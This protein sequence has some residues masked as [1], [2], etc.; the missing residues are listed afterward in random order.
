[1]FDELIVLTAELGIEGIFPLLIVPLI[2]PLGLMF[3]FIGFA[4]AFQSRLFL[5]LSIAT[6]LAIPVIF[7]D[8]NVLRGLVLRSDATELVPISVK[9]FGIGYGIGFLASMPF[10]ALQ[11]AGALTDTFRGENDTGLH[12]PTGGTLHTFSTIYLVVGFFTFF[13]VG[14]FET[15][16]DSFYATY[17]V[18]PIGS[19][20]PTMDHMAAMKVMDILT[21]TIYEAFRI[22]LPLLSVLILIEFSLSIAARLGRRFNMYDLA[23]PIKNLTTLLIMPLIIWIVWSLSEDRFASSASPLEILQRLIQ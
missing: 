2:R 16:L 4:W 13:S 23:F 10:F 8:L 3:G 18:W 1:M 7:I 14:G 22:A 19:I 15:M 6:T 11:Y 9:E 17:R 12:D 21:Q 5:R 20:F